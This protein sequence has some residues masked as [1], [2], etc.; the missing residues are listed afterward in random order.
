[1]A[2]GDP[3]PVREEDSFDVAA[4]ATWLGTE[5]PEVRQFL[6]GASNLT[7]LLRYADRDLI[8]RR[9]PTGHKAK[10]A[11]DMGREY[12]IQKALKPG[13]GLVPEMVGYC[14]DESVIGSPFYVMERLD[15]TILRRDLP[16]GMSLDP[17]QARALCENA[18]DVLIALHRVSP[19]EA[20]LAD[21]GRGPGYVARQ[22]AD[23]LGNVAAGKPTSPTFREAL[24]TQAVCDAVLDQLRASPFAYDAIN[25]TAIDP[26]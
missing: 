11:H 12:R 23:F 13:F 19:D 8:L 10:S 25:P 2:E 14:D 18:L 20:G 24:A 16:S 9:P 3:K 7:Y 5:V 22:V 1:V 4:V 6:G 26:T 21:L 17:A 15:G